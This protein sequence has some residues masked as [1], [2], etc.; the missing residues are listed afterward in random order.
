MKTYTDFMEEISPTELYEGMLGFGMFSEKIPPAFS[1]KSFYDYCEANNPS[2]DDKWRSYIQYDSMRNTNVIRELGIP[3]PM[4]YQQLCDCIQANWANIISHFSQCTSTQQHIISRIHIRKM[5]ATSALFQMNYDNWKEDGSPE[6]DLLIGSRYIVH[7]DI[8]KCFPSI[9]SHSLPWALV[10]RPEAKAHAGKIHIALWY[11]QIDHFVQNCKYGETHGLLIGPHTSNLLA[12]IILTAVDKE[13]YDKG[14]KY[15]RH[16]DDYTC[17]V[18]S[19]EKAQLFL[20]DL[21]TE[22]RKFDLSV[23]DKKTEISELPVALTEQWTRQ[24][25]NP[26]SFYRNGLFDYISTRS[27]FD[28]AIEI[29]QKNNEDSA[30]LNYAIKALPIEN[31]TAQAKLLAVKTIFHLCLLYPYLVHIMDEFVFERFCVTHKDIDDFSNRL[32]EQELAVKNYDAVC[33]ALFFSMK[34]DFEITK[35]SAKDAVGSDSCI[36]KLFAF[37]QFKK[38]KNTAEKAILRSHAVTLKRNEEDFDRNWLFIYEV[39]PQSD[40]PANWKTMKQN[41]ISFLKTEY[42]A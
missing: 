9:Y 40:L 35:L 7:A 31:M 25:G 15:T 8:S 34:Y 17:Y 36:Y 29:M 28:S 27:Y 22:L 5:K 13:L 12:E 30:I 23:N 2:F 11:N 26:K 39:L 32:F 16:I 33:Y 41:K 14:W 10:T 38:G 42:Q 19:A 21:N 24:I 6:L 4:A 20:V 1:S 18:E 3:T 37:L